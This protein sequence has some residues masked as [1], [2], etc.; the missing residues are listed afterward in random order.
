M[1]LALP[2]WL[3]DPRRWLTDGEPTAAAVEQALAAEDPAERELVA[4]LSPAAR[5]YLEAMARRAQALTRH[6][7][8]SVISLYTPLYLAN[9]CS[10]GCAYCGFASDRGQAR[11]ALDL[12]QVERELAAIKALGLAEVLLLTGERCPQA[13]F[14]Y[15]RRCVALAAAWFPAVGVEAFTMT[16]TEYHQLA[17]AGATSVTVYQE[18]Y[19]PEQYDRLHRWGPKK[20]YTA[21]IEAPARAMAAGI[22]N[23]GL[24][25][26]LGLSEPRAE[27]LC[28]FQHVHHLRRSYWRS[29]VA[30]SFPRLRPQ[31]GEFTAPHPVDEVWLAQMVFAMRLVLPDVPLLLSTRER[32]GFRDGMAGVGISK[33]SVASRTTVGGYAAPGS[34]DLAQFDVS[35]ERGVAEFCAMLRR[36]QLEPVFKNWDAAY[37]DPQ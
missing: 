16:T 30:L 24:G 6:H 32:P 34:D 31:V 26:L 27:A 4:L 22:R 33:M 19:D 7:F 36:H 12:P 5:P 8:G 2:P 11:Q 29:G 20:D 21:R 23:V 28:L 3:T 17:E 15:L 37:R 10:S 1:T 9:H 14:G 13:D 35:D 18:T 25:A